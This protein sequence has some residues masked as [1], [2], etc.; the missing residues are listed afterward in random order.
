MAQREILPRSI[1]FTGPDG[2]GK[3]GFALLT[4]DMLR[5]EKQKVVFCPFPFL[6]GTASGA[7]LRSAK[8]EGVSKIATYPLFAMNRYEVLPAIQEWVAK[9]D[10]HWVV[11][12]RVWQDGPVFASALGLPA[13]HWRFDR[14]YKQERGIPIGDPKQEFRDWLHALEVW[15]PDVWRGFYVTR[16]LRES[17]Q[18]MS[19]RGGAEALKDAFDKN[20]RL[21]RL[22]RRYFPMEFDRLSNWTTV[23]VKGVMATSDAIRAWQVPYMKKMWNEISEQSGNFEWMRDDIERIQNAQGRVARRTDIS[24]KEIRYTKEKLSRPA[25]YEWPFHGVR[26]WMPEKEPLASPIHEENVERN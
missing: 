20:V 8:K 12:D 16:P 19:Q 24:R 4:I 21:Q 13:E 22:V 9:G 14:R 11:F 1:G 23:R 10:D 5:R 6:S 25:H 17:I 3:T 26:N 18:I 7:M 15:F 2:T